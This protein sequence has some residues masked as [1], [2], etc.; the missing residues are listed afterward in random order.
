[1]GKVKQPLILAQHR[2]VPTNPVIQ[3]SYSINEQPT[4]QLVFIGFKV[5]CDEKYF[6]TMPLALLLFLH[7]SQTW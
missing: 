3:N 2:N 7:Q 1:M 4:A 5:K 6:I